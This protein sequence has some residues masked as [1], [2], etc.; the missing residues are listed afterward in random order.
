[1]KVKE[2][3]RAEWLKANQV[4][5][6]YHDRTGTHEHA[7]DFVIFDMVMITIWVTFL[8]DNLFIMFG[9]IFKRQAIGAPMG[10]NCS[11]DLV[12]LYL[13]CFEL[14][15]VEQLSTIYKTPSSPPPLVLLFLLLQRAYLSLVQVCL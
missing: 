8:L 1:M 9:H 4:P 14:V 13:S 7:G 2:N 15:F 3:E 5:D 6:V 10:A 12:N 11:G